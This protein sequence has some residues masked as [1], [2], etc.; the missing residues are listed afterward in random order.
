MYYKSGDSGYRLLILVLLIKKIIIS[1]MYYKSGDSGYRLLILV[2]LIKKIIIYSM[3][4]N[5]GGS[6][7]NPRN[8]ISTYRRNYERHRHSS[9][10]V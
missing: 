9:D 8:I 6:R 7:R 1:S 5:F 10:Y 2:L 4:F 3:Y